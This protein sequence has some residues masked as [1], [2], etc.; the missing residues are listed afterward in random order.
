M[1]KKKICWMDVSE[2]RALHSF[3]PFTNSVGK[4]ISDIMFP[5]ADY[6]AKA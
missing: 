4:P 1:Y 2:V 3:K 5:C 6:K